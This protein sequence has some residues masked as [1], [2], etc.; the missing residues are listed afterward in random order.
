MT[1]WFQFHS[2]DQSMMDWIYSSLLNTNSSHERWILIFLMSSRSARFFINL[3]F[4]TWR[5]NSSSS[6]TSSSPYDGLI[7]TSSV[8]VSVILA[9]STDQF[10]KG[11]PKPSTATFHTFFRQVSGSSKTTATIFYNFCR[12]SHRFFHRK[13]QYRCLELEASFSVRSLE[14]LRR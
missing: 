12:S 3:D 8:L 7:T 4:N 2:S 14:S 1:V 6:I 9:Y 10:Y 5:S 13:S 11:L